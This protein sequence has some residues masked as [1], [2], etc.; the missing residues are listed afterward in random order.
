MKHLFID[1]NIWLSLYHFSGADLT[2][3]SKLKDYLGES[4][5]L[6]CTEQVY[7]EL[8]RNRE[9]KINDSFAK[10]KI[11]KLSYPA[12]CKSYEEY[13]D[14][15]KDYSE[16]INRLD[17]WKKKI[18]N[19]IEKK[20]LAADLLIEDLFEKA[21]IIKCDGYVDKAVNR[22]HIGN[23]PGKDNKYG[24]AINWE[25]LLS[26]VPEGEDLYLISAD[27]D[28]R[29]ILFDRNINPY[30]EFEWKRTKKSNIFFYTDLLSFINTHLK[31]ILLEDEKT[32][33]SL[34]DELAKS[35]SYLETHGIIAKLGKQSGWNESHIDK[36]CSCLINNGQV[37]R[38]IEDDD[39]FEFYDDLLSNYYFE[40]LEEG[41]I[42]EACD[43]L[44]EIRKKYIPF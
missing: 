4:I 18:K 7:N 22:Y 15:S 38:I 24:D 27:R 8:I 2:Q 44:N 23:P 12:F 10:F 37:S 32:K 1:T 30:L 34:I 6:Y 3:F 20:Q 16:L 33:Q 5:K 29:S 28:Y 13:S 35:H 31:D 25:C 40:D 42:K 43:M 26:Q 41:N 19:D 14:F 11:D 9:S 39:V 17:T 21:G 36:L